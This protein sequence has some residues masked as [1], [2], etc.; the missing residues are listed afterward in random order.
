M[1]HWEKIAQ[2]ATISERSA[3][4]KRQYADLEIAVI[5]PCKD[6]EA[7][8]AQ[9]IEGFQ[10]ALPNAKIYVF[11]NNS[12]D[13]TALVARSAGAMVYR[14]MHPGKGNVVRRMFADIDADIYVMADGDATYD[15]ASAP[16]MIETLML[17]NLDMV[18]GLREHQD[19][20]AYRH[21]H[22]FGNRLLT[23]MVKK[24][25]GYNLQDMLSGYRIFSRRFV[26]SFPRILVGLK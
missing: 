25:F 10:S 21:G 12:A 20:S 13:H 23:G 16:D 5:L 24:I 3:A 8:I 9:T 19:Q 26:K 15:A 1:D 14:A 22:Q 7:A 11:D 18:T 6:E 2:N 4:F 17:E